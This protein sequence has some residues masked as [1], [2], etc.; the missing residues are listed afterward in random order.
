MCSH[1]GKTF[2]CG[3]VKSRD[4]TSPHLK[5]FPKCSAWS[6]H[7]IGILLQM[8]QNSDDVRCVW[9]RGGDRVG[10]VRAVH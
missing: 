6:E 7:G 3:E 4:L 1:L 10:R 2:K 9:V 5:V 8:E